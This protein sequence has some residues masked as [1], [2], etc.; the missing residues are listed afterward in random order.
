MAQIARFLVASPGDA[1]LRE[2]MAEKVREL[3]QDIA[4][5]TRMRDSLRHASA[6]THTPLIECPEFKSHIREGD[7]AW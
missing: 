4:R 5:L 7:A 1:E 3:D 2:R 6:C